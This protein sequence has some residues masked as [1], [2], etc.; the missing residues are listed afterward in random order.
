MNMHKWLSI[1]K[2]PG[3]QNSVTWSV[4]LRQNCCCK[5]GGVVYCMTIEAAVPASSTQE[6]PTVVSVHAYTKNY[7]P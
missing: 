5:R 3:R 4:L 6:V 2:P 1:C 7:L